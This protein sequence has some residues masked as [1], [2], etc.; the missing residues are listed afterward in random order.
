MK[1]KFLGAARTVTGSCFILEAMGHRFAIDCGM[2]QGNRAIDRRNWDAEPY[3]PEDIEFFLI[4]HAHIDHTGLLPRMVREGFRG[5]I[6][7]TIPTMDLLSIML[8]DSAHLQEMDANW[9]NKKKLR[10]GNGKVQPLYTTKDAEAT[11]PLC[12]G[13]PYEQLFEPFPGFKVNFRDAGHILGASIIELWIEERGREVKLVF[14]GDIG[15]P[16]Q[17]LMEEPSAVTEADFLFVESTYGNRNHKNEDD[18]L[19][20][21][22][23]AIAYS[24]RNGEKVV[25]PAFAVE[26]TQEMLYSLY[27]LS[28]D[29]RLPPDMP[30]YIDSPMA[31]HVTEIFRRHTDY[32][33]DETRALIDK[34]ENPLHLPQLHL[35]MTTEESMAIN[36]QRGP[37]IVISASGMADAGRIRHHLRHNLWRRGA[38]LVF[39]GFQAQG[40]TGRKIVDGAKTIRLFNEDIAVKAK[41]FTINGFSAHAGQD[42]LLDWIGRF[43][44]RQMQIF[45]VHGEYAAQQALAARIRE[46]YGFEAVIPDYLEEIDLIP[47]EE[48]KRVGPPERAAPRIDWEELLGNMESGFARLR[49]RKTSLDGKPWVEQT[50]LRDRLA[51]LNRDLNAVISEL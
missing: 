30:V 48:L 26:R 47:G 41:V 13:I 50:E 1:I 45:L 18:T 17:L 21:L 14:S 10:R 7:M 32:F 9:R 29:G 39:V 49:E 15:R 40:T 8:M 37:A 35:S 24:Y 25:I 31:I 5:P 23:E 42:Q 2:H 44:N 11:L 38:S 46:L 20:E 12:K 4:T 22:V 34:G 19:A 28:K 3:E 33:D 27:L 43:E 51:E 16:A 6:Y 36:E